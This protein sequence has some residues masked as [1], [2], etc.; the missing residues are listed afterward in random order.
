MMGD[1]KG[2]SASRG[3]PRPLGGA[4]GGASATP[5]HSAAR[6]KQAGRSGR[7]PGA[8]EAERRR[9]RELWGPRRRPGSRG[10]GPGSASPKRGLTLELSPGARRGGPP[11][12]EAP[13]GSQVSWSLERTR[14]PWGGSGTGDPGRPLLPR[15]PPWAPCVKLMP[16]AC[17]PRQDGLTPAAWQEEPD[18]KVLVLA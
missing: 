6:P 2:G 13:R 18:L 9:W 1:S 11:Q 7:Q 8:L 12:D 16:P 10:Q 5:L 17:G 3:T 4:A 14:S 15:T